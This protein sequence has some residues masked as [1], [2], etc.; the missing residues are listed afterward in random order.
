MFKWICLIK[1]KQGISRKEFIDYYENNHVP[2][3]LHMFPEFK[4]ALTYR[5]NYIVFD[6]PVVAIEERE[7]VRDQANFDVMTEVIFATREEA[8]ALLTAAFRK[9]DNAAI[10]QADEDHFIERGNALMYVVE[11][12]ETEFAMPSA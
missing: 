6:D 7:G 1:K 5:R 10:V 2:L 3:V 12:Y 9:P 8:N 11:T 4:T